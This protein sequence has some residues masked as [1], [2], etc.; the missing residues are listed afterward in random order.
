M[1]F[2]IFFTSYPVIFW[3]F[4]KRSANPLGARD[5]LTF[6]SIWCWRKNYKQIL[7]HITSNR[8]FTFMASLPFFLTHTQKGCLI[9]LLWVQPSYSSPHTQ[10][11][12]GLKMICPYQSENY[13]LCF[14]RIVLHMRFTA[15]LNFP[16]T[17]SPPF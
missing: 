8:L 15:W 2:I 10:P 13:S 5:L 12:R 4:A 7:P 6:I 17:H 9:P 3:I 14:W 16:P 11:S 1:I